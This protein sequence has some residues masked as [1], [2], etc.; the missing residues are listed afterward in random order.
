MSKTARNDI[1][2]DAI[3]SKKTSEKYRENWD[4]IF[5]NKNKDLNSNSKKTK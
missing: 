2:G 5:A 1:T 3:Q 4:R